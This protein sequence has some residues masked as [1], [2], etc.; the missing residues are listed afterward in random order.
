ML[1][2]MKSDLRICSTAERNVSSF[3]GHGPRDIEGE[4]PMGLPQRQQEHGQAVD[5]V[6]RQKIGIKA[7][8]YCVG[9]LNAF[10]EETP[11]RFAFR[12]FGEIQQVYPCGEGASPNPLRAIFSPVPISPRLARGA[13]TGARQTRPSVH[14][15][16]RPRLLVGRALER[17][18]GI[19]WIWRSIT[20]T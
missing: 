11:S 12:R 13:R 7:Y 20:V 2:R 17:S 5:E 1:R 14:C 16:R 8:Y 6:L 18:S 10:L 3:A 19:S 4:L 15:E 9:I